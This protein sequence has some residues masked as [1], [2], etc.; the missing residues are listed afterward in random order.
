MLLYTGLSHTRT[1]TYNGHPQC[2]YIPVSHILEPIRITSTHNVVIYRFVTRQNQYVLR[3]P[4]MLLYTGLSHAR[5]NT[6]YVHPQCCYIPVCDTLEPIRITYTHMLLYTGLSHTRTNTYYVHN[7]CRY[8]PVCHTLE[9]IRITYTT[10]LLYTG[11]SQTRTNTYYVHP[12]CC[13]IP[14]CHTLEPI[15]ITYTHNVAIYRFVTRQN[16]YV[17]RTPTMLLYTGLSH[18]RTNTYYVHPQCCYIPVCHTLE[19]IR[20]TY[21]HN[22]AIYRFCHTLEPI[23]I[24][25]TH[26]VAIYRFVTHQNQYVLRT[27]TML[28]YTGLSHTRTNTYYVHHNV[29]IYRFVTHQNQY[30]LRTPT[31]LLYTGFVTHQNQYVLR[32]PTM[33]LYTGL[34]HARTNTYYV[35]P[36]CC[37]I[38]VCH[39]LE[40]IRITY[41][42]NVA[43][44]RFVTRQ[45]QYVL[46]TPTMLLYTGLSDIRTNTYYVHPQCCYIPVCHT[47][48]PI[49]I[50]YTHNVVIYRFVTRQN[51]YVLRTPTMLLYTGLSDTRTN[52]YYVHPQCCYIPVCHTLEPIRI[53]DTHNVV[54]YR[55]VT[56]QNQYVLRTPTMLL[57]T[58]LSHTR[59]NTYN[60][61]P[62]CC[63]IPVSH[64][65]NQYVLRP[66]TM[67]LY[68]GLSHARTNTYYVHPQCCYIPVCHTLE[69]IRIMYTHNVVIYRFVTHQNQ[70]VLRTPSMS[71]YTGLSHTR[72][73]TYYVHPQCCYIPVCH[74]LEPIRI[75][76]TH[77]VVIYRFVTHQ[78]QYVL[79]TPTMLLYTGLSHSRTNTYY[80]HPE[81]CYIPVCHTLEPIRITYTHNVV[82]YRFV[83]RQ[84]Q[85]VLRPPTM[86]LYTGLSHARTNTYYVHPQC[87]Y[88]P[89]CHTL[90]PIRITYTHNVVI[91]RCVTRQNQYVLRTPTMLLYTGLSHT[92][93]NMYYVHPQCCYI[94]VCHTLEPIRITYTHNVVIYRFVTHQNQYVL[95][96]PT[97]LLYTG[98]S[99]TRTNTYYVHPQCCYIPVCHTR[100]NTYY[101]HP[102]CCYIPVCHTLE[103]I[104]IMCTDNVVI[105][106]FVTLQNQYVLLTPTM[107]LYTGLSHTRTNTYQVH[108]QCCYIPVCHTLE[109]IRISYTHNVVIYRFVTRQ[110]QYV[111]RTPTMLLYTGLSHTRTNTYYVHPQCCY[112]PVCQTL[113]PIRIY[114][115]PQCC[116]IPVCHTL[117]P[118]RIT[119]THNVVIYRFVTLQNQY[120]LRTPTMLLYTGLSHT[121]TNMYNGH[122]QCCYIPVSHTLEPIRITSTHNVVIYR[123]VTRQNQYVLRT[124]TMLLYTGLSHARTNTYYVHP[125]CRYIQVCH[126]LEPIRITY[127]HNVV[128]YRFVTHQNQYVLRTPTM[129][130]YTGLSHTRTNTYY[131]HPQCCY[132]P[133]CH[134]LEPIRITY[135]HNVVI[136]RFVTHQNQY[137]LRTPQCYYIPVCHTL[138]PIRITYTHNVVIY[139]F[140]THQNQYVL[141]TPTILL[142]T[143]LSHAR[144]NTYYVHPQCCYIP[145]C[146]TLEPIRITYTHNVVIYRFVIHQ[147]QYVLRTPTMLLYTGLSHTRTNTYY[148]HPQCCY[149]PVCHTLEP[150]RITYTHNVA[151]YRFVTRQN[152]YVLRTPTMLLYTGLSHTR[153]NTYYVHHNVIIYRFV[154]HQ[155]QY[156]LRTPTM[157]LYTGLSH[158]R[159]NTYYVHPQCCYIP[160]CHTLEPIRIT[161][162]HNVVIYRF[163]T[164]QNQYVLR[165]PTMLLY[166]G[167]SHTRTNT[168]YLHP[169]C[170]YIPVCHTLEPIRI[171][172]T[173]NVVIHRFVTHQNQYVLRTPQCY[174]IPVCHTLEPIRITYTHNVVI[175]RFVTHQNQYVLR[176]PTML[177]YTGLS[178]ARTNTYYVHPQCCYIPVCH[179]LEPIRITYTHNVAIYRFVTRQNQYVLCTPTMLLYTGLSDIRTN[180]YYVHPQCC[181]IPVCH[182]LEPIRITYTHNVVIY[183]FVTR[184]NQYVLRT[185]TMLL[186][187]G[188]SHSRTNTYYVHPQ[189]CYIPVCQTL[190]PIRIM[191]THNVVIYRFVTLQ[192][193]YV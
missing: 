183:R 82:I 77:N 87:C 43:I 88:I 104:R 156:V 2:C 153:T 23:R 160:V 89:V 161:Y 96:T 42:H 66:P 136:H 64:T 114:V 5:T 60:G 102:Q 59:T 111:L 55:F 175:Y 99:H 14:V 63:Y 174:Y 24:T 149:I 7:R 83:T 93:T 98:L 3:T 46:C 76:Y 128:I 168:Y 80:V 8:T 134:T 143:G 158:T 20:I 193:Q 6:Y 91:Y 190:E 141:R 180:T 171:T 116:Y 10:M 146:H 122:P 140:V 94:P 188:L 154:T 61:H 51:Q 34:S 103:P 166:T 178:H 57:Y 173:H 107:L 33:L 70:Y 9:P 52:T 109:P 73:N 127:T 142:Y 117:E 79:R 21:T 119:D 152:Q 118:I 68:T 110:N 189:C 172:Y 157:L 100:T 16:Q 29:I 101:V 133:V 22:V 48:E 18:T 185:P 151:I 135:T 11:L 169:Q 191:Y 47:L 170:C 74:T 81:C 12:Q 159:T 45:N 1:N 67:L 165:T 95:R 44:Y 78:N 69:P 177:L 65:E 50:T 54:I 72:T 106:R 56:L 113:E 92:R 121:R 49:R 39:T 155:N 162:T 131:V 26:N 184:Q 62:Q 41:T 13:Y 130:L 19:P 124:P 120:V 58:G 84:N 4:T 144:T 163:V 90:E 86:L 53:T 192:N 85:Y 123:F 176:T 181:Y 27:P 179:T 28:L 25:Y 115:H 182:T 15:R 35:H 132:I 40:P 164:H 126:T 105:Y 97:M 38:P 32:T 138:E 125:Q 30:V 139:R 108:P 137:V 71:L 147:N 187:T 17:L 186:Y 167:L 129:L 37:Y 75:T 145:F 148:V 36:Q 150:I 31:M 112:I